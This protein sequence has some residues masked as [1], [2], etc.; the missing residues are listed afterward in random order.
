VSWSTPESLRAQVQR[1]WDRGR[2]LANLV[3]EASP[4]PVRL[5]FKG[6]SSREVSE[7]FEEARVWIARLKADE[8]TGEVGG[9]RLVWREVQHRVLGTN[10]IPVEAWIDTLDDAVA[11]IGRRREVERFRAV[12]AR[13]QAEQPQLIPWLARYPLRALDA[14]NDW[15]RLLQVVRWLQSRPRP[16]VYSRQVDLPGVH[17]KFIEAHRSVLGELLDLTLPVGAIDSEATGKA[18]FDRRYGFR[19]K[20]LLVRFRVLDA[21]AALLPAGPDM[22]LTVTAGDFSLLEVSVA[23]VFVTENEINYLAFP[24][25]ASSLV[26]FGAGYGF[27]NLAA[28]RWLESRDLYYWSDIDTHG[29]AMLDQF[30][31]KFGHARSFLMD[32]ATLLAHR[33]LWGQEPQP[34]VRDLTR[35]DDTERTLYADLRDGRLG[36]RVR[37]EQ[38][39][40]GYGWLEQACRRTGG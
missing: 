33:D 32:R 36:D 23:R 7:R 3:G 16:D 9:Y 1:L 29:F 13:T 18:V 19:Q 12:V 2:L 27:E 21:S 4:F 8:K 11:V 24:R 37:L 17:S 34:A 6:P 22:D 26:I 28:S 14:G 20:P 25:V 38:E 15:D 10:R 39:R 31:A 35:L 5:T 30:R 40:I